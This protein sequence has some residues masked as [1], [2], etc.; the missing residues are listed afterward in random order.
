MN[1]KEKDEKG[2]GLKRKGLK[3]KKG[4]GINWQ[5]IKLLLLRSKLSNDKDELIPFPKKG[6]GLK[7]MYTRYAKQKWMENWNGG[8]I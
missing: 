1:K 7:R 8:R 6:K 2:K 5:R 3:R 4:K